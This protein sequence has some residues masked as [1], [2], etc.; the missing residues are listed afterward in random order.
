[1]GSLSAKNSREKFSRLGTFKETVSRDGYFFECL[2]I[3]IST[4]CVC[5][6]SFQGL[7]TFFS[8]LKLLTSF[9]NATETLNFLHYNCSMFT[10]ADLSLGTGKMCLGYDVKETQAASRENFQNPRFRVFDA[11][12]WKAFQS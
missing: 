4:F 5:A 3:L 10:S 12:F 11:G 7:S 8:F 1:M 6:D 2:N 9:E